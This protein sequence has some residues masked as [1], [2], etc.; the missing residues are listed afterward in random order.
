MQIEVKAIVVGRSIG[1]NDVY[2][3]ENI[4]TGKQVSLVS[5]GTEIELGT[6]GEFMYSQGQVNKMI[7]FEPVTILEEELA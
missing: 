3:L 7:N 2:I 6:E 5:N 1:E 4:N